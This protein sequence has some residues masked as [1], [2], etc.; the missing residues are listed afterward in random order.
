M[1]WKCLH[2][3]GQAKP[4][5]AGI[6]SDVANFQQAFMGDLLMPYVEQLVKASQPMVELPH[7]LFD[8]K[9]RSWMTL[10]KKDAK[11]LW[12]RERLP[13]WEEFKSTPLNLNRTTSC[14]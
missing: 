1:L 10:F 12:E 14:P 13:S 2:C 8:A 9:R 4:T 11:K 7:V 5:D 6:I 3:K